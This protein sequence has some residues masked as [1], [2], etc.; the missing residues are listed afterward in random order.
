[1]KQ[2]KYKF[3]FEKS[4]AWARA[5]IMGNYGYDSRDRLFPISWRD[6]HNMD[7]IAMGYMTGRID[8]NE[9][10]KIM[11]F[12]K[13]ERNIIGRGIDFVKEVSTSQRIAREITN[14]ARKAVT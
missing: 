11:I 8:E 6:G 13:I 4:A 9:A 2:L 3:G 14:I 10:V 5:K 7:D 1:M 12:A